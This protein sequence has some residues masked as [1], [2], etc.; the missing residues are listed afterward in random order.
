MKK[1]VDQAAKEKKVYKT[2]NAMD[3]TFII[4][5]SKS[6]KPGKFEKDLAV[7]QGIF[8]KG[9]DNISIADRYTLINIYNVAFHESGKIEGI[10]S[11]DS[12]ATNCAF[13]KA[14][15]AAANGDNDHICTHCYDMTQEAYRFAALNRHTLNMLI[16]QTV[17]F[18]IEELRM[19]PAS[20]IVRVNSSGDAPNKTYAL[21]MLRYA[22]AHDSANVA[23]WT[24]NHIV[25][26]QAIKEI[27]YKPANVILIK[28]SRYINKPEKLPEFFDYVF[29]VYNNKT[30][31]EEAIKN[32]AMACN[33]KKCMEC[34][35][36]CYFGKWPKGSN[37]A[38]LLR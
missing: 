12:S 10:S 35:F 7:V 27:G 15:R 34:G 32:G 25:Y 20:G 3:C 2:V 19:L 29:T 13:C 37:I 38:E 30:A 11:L 14:C 31:V 9:I 1:A 36:S 4:E 28:S 16:M 21:N 22:I 8:E 5:V 23:V 17:E 6:G 26:I 33:G 18:S 24:K